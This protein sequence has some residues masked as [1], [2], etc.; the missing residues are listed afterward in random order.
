M[1]VICSTMKLIK[2][3]FYFV[4]LRERRKRGNEDVIGC[5]PADQSQFSLICA[6]SINYMD[7]GTTN[8]TAE[9]V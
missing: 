5:C 8:P 6:F 1:G 4:S 7:T 3:W 9:Q 2:F